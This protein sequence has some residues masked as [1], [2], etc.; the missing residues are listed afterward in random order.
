MYPNDGRNHHDGIANELSTIYM[1]NNNP[2]LAPIR[3][4]LG[5]LVHKGGTSMN[6]DA[7][8]EETG[9]KVSM[10]NKESESGSFDW[11]NMSF[12][13]KDFNEIHQSI[14]KFYKKFPEDEQWVRNTYRELFH[15]ICKTIDPNVM[16]NRVLDGHDSEWILVNFRKK[17]EM[18]LFHRDELLELW[19]NPGK[20]IVNNK[21]ASGKIE[22][23]PNLRI[24]ICL[25]NGIKA[26]L[27]RG[28]TIC[29]KIQ[30]DQ[31]RKLLK[32]LTKSIVCVY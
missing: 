2:K 14:I 17:R 22:G 29:V 6:P 19:K 5:H 28:S 13:D 16:L 26:L 15:I 30:Q 24:R 9:V 3:E 20:C 32:Q 31:P 11:K 4:K 10:K 25:N 7:I 21:Y 1:I 18:T 8:C 27:G 12:T 23:T